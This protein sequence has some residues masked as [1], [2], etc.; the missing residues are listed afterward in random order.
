MT[1][2]SKVSGIDM[3]LVC[4]HVLLDSSVLLYSQELQRSCVFG[5]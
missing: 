5:V 2:N 1:Q 3:L 4:G